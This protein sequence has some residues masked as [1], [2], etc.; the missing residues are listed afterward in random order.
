MKT[1]DS[2]NDSL[3][4]DFVEGVIGD[5]M[6]KIFIQFIK[7]DGDLGKNKSTWLGEGSAT[8]SSWPPI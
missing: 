8:L 3:S 2:G 1:F 4:I 5:L 6:A 7:S